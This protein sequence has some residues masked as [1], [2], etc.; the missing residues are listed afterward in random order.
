MPGRTITLDIEQILSELETY[1]TTGNS[2]FLAELILEFY[3]E[4]Q[5]SYSQ[6]QDNDK[7]VPDS[8]RQQKGY[9]KRWMKETSVKKYLGTFFN[10]VCEIDDALPQKLRQEKIELKSRINELEYQLSSFKQADIDLKEK[11]IQNEVQLRLDHY[12]EDRDERIQKQSERIQTLTAEII[13]FEQMEDLAKMS[14]NKPEQD[15]S[16]LTSINKELLSKIKDLQSEN[17]DLKVENKQLKRRENAKK[18]NKGTNKK[19]K[20]KQDSSSDES[21]SD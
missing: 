5:Y 12:V 6:Y 19:K 4:G 7:P 14:S 15:E 17:Y 2:D 21:D 8:C 16:E 11:A 13:R 10:V 20:K 3:K 18:K 9:I 1:N